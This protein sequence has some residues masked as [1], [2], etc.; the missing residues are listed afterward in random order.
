MLYKIVMRHSRQVD[1]HSGTLL[2]GDFDPFLYLLIFPL[3]HSL[4]V[5]T[6]H[7]IYKWTRPRSGPTKCRA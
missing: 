2:L 5:S 3:T 7:Y 1:L 6:A 4:L